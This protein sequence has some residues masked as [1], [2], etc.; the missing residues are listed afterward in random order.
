MDRVTV[1]LMVALAGLAMVAAGLVWKFGAYGL[2]GAGVGILT[3]A[4]VFNIDGRS[5]K[6]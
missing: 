1:F 6:P 2:V 3:V 5:K 4:F